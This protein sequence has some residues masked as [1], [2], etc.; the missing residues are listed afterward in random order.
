[1]RLALRQ[2]NVRRKLG[3][4][5]MALGAPR[6]M[7]AARLLHCHFL[8]HGDH[9]LAVAVIQAAGVAPNLGQETEFVVRKLG[10]GLRSVVVARFREKV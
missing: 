3:K 9:Q 1:M 6:S 2:D 4:K 8:D 7:L 5:E 10:E